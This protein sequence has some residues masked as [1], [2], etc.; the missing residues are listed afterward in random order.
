MDTTAIERLCGAENVPR[1]VAALTLVVEGSF[2][3]CPARLTRDA[4]KDRVALCLALLVRLKGDL[5]WS[6]PRALDH[7]PEYL[8]FELQGVKYEPATGSTW[9]AGGEKRSRGGLVLAGA[10]G[11]SVR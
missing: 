9:T 6:L 7:I 3:V 11:L 8:V 4:V 2:A 5:K 1:V 10:P